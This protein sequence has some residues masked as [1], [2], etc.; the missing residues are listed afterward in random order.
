LDLFDP[1]TTTDTWAAKEID[2]DK[3]KLDAQD[4][5]E[6]TAQF[7]RSVYNSL[8]KMEESYGSVQQAVNL[9]QEDLRIKRLK[10]D[11]GMAT[12]T[13]VQAAELALQDKQKTLDNLVFQHEAWKVVFDKPWTYTVLLSTSS[14][15]A[16]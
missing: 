13:D 9:A 16:E 11:I 15:T 3:A 7:V 10:M 1:S 6:Q 8:L 5:R 4:A 12:K 2:I 14:S